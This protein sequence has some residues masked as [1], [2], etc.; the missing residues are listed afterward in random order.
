[1]SKKTHEVE[2]KRSKSIEEGEF[3]VA[4]LSKVSIVDLVFDI[5]IN[6]NT[7]GQT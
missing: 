7:N 4:N 1:M 5:T 3:V 6:S 2:R